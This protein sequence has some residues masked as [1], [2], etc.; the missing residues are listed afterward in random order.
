MEDRE[1]GCICQIRCMCT[2]PA[3]LRDTCHVHDNM[4]TCTCMHTVDVY[5]LTCTHAHAHTP[6]LT[7]VHTHSH[8]LTHTYTH[9]CMYTH[10]HTYLIP[11][12]AAAGVKKGEIGGTGLDV[13]VIGVGGVEL[14]PSPPDIL[15]FNKQLLTWSSL[16]NQVWQQRCVCVCVKTLY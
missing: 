9:V 10:T 5:H 11:A 15:H 4:H 3:A 16:Q 14:E 8:T 12:A 2:S 13:D 6:P 7:H 1:W